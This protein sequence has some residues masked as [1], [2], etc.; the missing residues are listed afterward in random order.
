MQPPTIELIPLRPALC[1]DSPTTLDVLLKITPPRLI[2]TP[3]SP[4]RSS[5]SDSSS[6]IPARWVPTGR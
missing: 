1:S 4:D 3:K 5:I 6:I 2:P